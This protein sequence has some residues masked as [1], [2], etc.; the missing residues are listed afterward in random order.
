MMIEYFEIELSKVTLQ[1]RFNKDLKLF[2]DKGYE[3]TIKELKNNLIGYDWIRVLNRK[4]VSKIIR[5][6]VLSC[7]IFLK[8]KR[9]GKVK[10][11]RCAN[12]ILLRSFVLY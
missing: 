11:R 8:K 5:L 10:A 7:L 12:R 6:K 3:V 4:K 1:Y 9:N 2:R